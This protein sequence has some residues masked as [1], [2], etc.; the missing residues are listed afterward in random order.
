MYRLDFGEVMGITLFAKKKIYLKGKCQESFPSENELWLHWFVQKVRQICANPCQPNF[1]IGER[2]NEIIKVL[3]ICKNLCSK[4]KDPTSKPCTRVR[5]TEAITDYRITDVRRIEYQFKFKDSPMMKVQEEYVIY[6]YVGLLS[7]VG[8]ILG[9]C[10]GI[11]F[12]GISE[13]L[14]TYMK[15]GI[16]W[17]QRH[18]GLEWI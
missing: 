18:K 15:A 1:Y 13:N 12:Y 6:D 16:N 17:I 7:S 9:I 11:S 14:V 5:Y 10:V 8:G 4:P 3:P 2:L